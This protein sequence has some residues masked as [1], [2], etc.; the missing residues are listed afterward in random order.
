MKHSEVRVVQAGGVVLTAAGSVHTSCLPPLDE[1][2]SLTFLCA[3]KMRFQ[4]FL[5]ARKII[6]FFIVPLT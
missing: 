4:R 5:K 3:D 1:L 2:H 6:H